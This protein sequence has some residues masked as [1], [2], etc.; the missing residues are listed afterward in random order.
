MKTCF[1]ICILLQAITALYSASISHLTR[2]LLSIHL[3]ER[4][5]DVINE[6]Q[7]DSDHF[8]R[9]LWVESQE[10][11]QTEDSAKN[12]STIFVIKET[13]C[14]KSGKNSDNCPFKENGVMKLCTA[15]YSKSVE[16][17]PI[18]SC[19]TFDA[20]TSNTS[21]ATP[22]KEKQRRRDVKLI[23]ADKNTIGTNLLDVSNKGVLQTQAIASCLT[24]I[25][26]YLPEFPG[27]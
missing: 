25:F 5:I 26:D 16:A 14:Q 27:K 21:T 17:E 15:G 11:S 18:V 19:Q 20:A 12:N 7:S 24:C 3:L 10:D 4:S 23:R 22:A 8:F 13:D 1:Q 6:K 2:R 9:M